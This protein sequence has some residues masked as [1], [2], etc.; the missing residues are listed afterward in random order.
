MR[1]MNCLNACL[2]AIATVVGWS[3]SAW[4]VPYASGV[5]NTGGNSWEFVLNQDTASVNIL[6]NG[7]NAL[8][9]G[10]LTKGRH[11]FDMTGFSTFDIEV[12]HNNVSAWSEISDPLNAFTKFNR[13]QG[14]EVNTNPAS[15]F[16]GTVYVANAAAGAT[17]SPVRTT[18]D[19]VYAMTAD[20][21]GVDLPTRAVIADPNDIVLQGKSFGWT[22]AP[23]TTSSP[24]RLA[25]DEAGN[26]IVSDWSDQSGG[27]KYALADLS[28]G[29]LVL[30]VEDGVR[31]L[32]PNINGDEVHGSIVSKP[33]VTGSVGN[34]LVL[35]GMDEDFSLDRNTAD[36]G[37]D[38]NHIWKWNVG[39][40]T[41]YDLPPDLHISSSALTVN[42]TDPIPHPKWLNL[43]VGVDANMFY[44]PVHNK[45]Y[46]TQNRNDG[47]EGGLVVVTADGVDGTT[48]T[49]DWSSIQWTS[50]NGLDSYPDD[51]DPLTL[52]DNGLNDAFRGLGS[53]VVS[54]DGTKLYIHHRQ[55]V[56]DAVGPPPV[57]SLY[58]GQSSNLSGN[59]LVIPLDANGL[60]VI[61]VNDNGTPLDSADDTFTNLDSITIAGNFTNK[62][63]HEI[64]L[65]AA[66]NR[67]QA[68]AVDRNL[69]GVGKQPAQRDAERTAHRAGKRRQHQRAAPDHE[70]G[71]DFLA[72]DHVAAFERFLQAFLGRIF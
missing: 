30:A 56:G 12:T 4:A 53:A 66:G 48:P 8:N 14:L 34:N 38:G 46:L 22:V 32:L 60:P 2:I 70:P 16:F 33:Y 47:T 51:T 7:G 52:G 26:L 64:T 11:T 49:I 6:R 50:D 27:V 44:S 9:L 72:L 10:A 61:N 58:T 42:T 25:L 28:N 55:V 15:P 29:G 13:P 36:A 24:H 68:P 20:L 37:T 18:G 45:W 5:R 19:G 31:P 39:N 63:A 23:S 40:A 65:D 3:A 59:V 57:I 69:V 41:D 43:N 35:Y 67:E 54:A 17:T 71:R 21:I 62:G 1:R